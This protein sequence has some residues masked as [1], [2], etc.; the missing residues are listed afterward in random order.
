[1]W[2]AGCIF[3]ELLRNEPLFPAKAEADT[4]E[5]MARLLGAPSERIW[6]VRPLLLDRPEWL[7]ADRRSTVHWTVQWAFSWSVVHPHLRAS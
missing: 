2:A 4:L 1:M 5:L 6:P 7:C 3:G